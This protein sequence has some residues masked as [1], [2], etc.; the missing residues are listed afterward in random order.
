MAAK[1]P[2]SILL[3]VAVFLI[4]AGAVY[5][6]FTQRSTEAPEQQSRD[7][8]P[9]VEGLNEGDVVNLPTLLSLDGQTVFL[10][11]LKENRVLCVFF[12]PSCS[13]CA[14]DVELWRDLKDES[15]KRGVAFYVIDVGNDTEA[16]KKLVAAYKLEAL[17]ILFDPNHR[18]GPA[19]KINFV[20]SYLLFA[21][22]GKVLHR[23]DGIR[24][25]ERAKGFEQI[26]KFFQYNGA[27]PQKSGPT[28]GSGQYRE[29]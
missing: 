29:R 28:L 21:S 14:K 12:S 5:F 7:K 23:W 6:S 17:P 13:G 11:Q 3:P 26:K 4:A 10:S 22:N 18:I 16:L 24:N 15:A 20:P 8:I 1:G 2:L 25:Y 9:G 27:L 19:L